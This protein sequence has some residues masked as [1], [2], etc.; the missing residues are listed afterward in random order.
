MWAARTAGHQEFDGERMASEDPTYVV[1]NGKIG[2]LTGSRALT[3]AV[4]ETIRIYFGVGGPNLVSSWHVIGEMF[5]TVWN[6][7]DVLSPPLQSVQTVLVPPG[8]AA[9]ADIRLDY[10]GDYILVDHSLTRTIDKGSLGIL[11]V[12]G[13][14]DD[15]IFKR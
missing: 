9:I 10:P 14:A 13:P 1:F 8:G 6:L 15:T 2:S 12:T 11:T 3:G 5:D 7:G 4:G